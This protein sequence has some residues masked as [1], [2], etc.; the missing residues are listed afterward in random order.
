[1]HVRSTS[2][3]WDWERFTINYMVFD[4][5]YKTAEALKLV[6]PAKQHSDRFDTL[7]QWL[8]LP[9]NSD[10]TAALAA[11]RNQLFHET[12]WN[13]QQPG[14]GSREGY[15]QADHLSRIN[16]RLL[17]ALANYRGPYL[18]T[19]WWGIGQAPM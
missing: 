13:R 1:M 19:P 6:T 17:F 15:I 9:Q 14:I 4:G 2:Y 8:N 18:S 3:E 10:V 5:C 7:F 12:L 11:S 16:D